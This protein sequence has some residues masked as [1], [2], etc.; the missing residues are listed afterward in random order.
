[1]SVIT[2]KKRG[3]PTLPA[4]LSKGSVTRLRLDADDVCNLA[5]A[6]HLFGAPT[7]SE[8]VRRALA[9]AVLDAGQHL[10]AE[11]RAEIIRSH[12]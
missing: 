3:R 1:M 12:A 9:W 11:Q 8:A 4:A 10:T 7:D 2:P 5:L 6:R